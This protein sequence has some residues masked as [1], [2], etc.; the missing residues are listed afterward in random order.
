MEDEHGEE[1][2]ERLRAL[3]GLEIERIMSDLLRRRDLLLRYWARGRVRTPFLDTTFH[4]YRTLP[5]GDLLLLDI[6]TARAVDAFYRELDE[7]RLYLGHT[8]DMPTALGRVLDNVVARLIPL[9]SASLLKL[10]HALGGADSREDPWDFW[11]HVQGEPWGLTGA[12][13]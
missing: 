6:P 5:A 10:G 8:D 12:E 13:E 7:L 11:T 4:R 9:A 2:D 3:L 1:R